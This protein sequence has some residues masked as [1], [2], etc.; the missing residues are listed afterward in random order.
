MVEIDDVKGYAGHAGTAVLVL[1]AVLLV[2]AALLLAL[3][4]R[5][6]DEHRGL[7]VAGKVF[8]GVGVVL[9]AILLAAGTAVHVLKDR[10]VD[11]LVPPEDTA[12]PSP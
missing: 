12:R 6:G 7:A 4:V 9:A 3:A 1:G 2:V 5:A 8:G 10:V 11:G